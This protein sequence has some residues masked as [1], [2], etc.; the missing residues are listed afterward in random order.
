VHADDRQP[1]VG[2][3]GDDLRV[4]R[5]ERV[6][7]VALGRAGAVEQ[8]LIEIRQRDAVALLVGLA[9]VPTLRAE[10]AVTMRRCA[11]SR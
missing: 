8:G 5:D 6:D 10:P 9:H 1:P 3:R 11:T 4:H 7:E 2:E